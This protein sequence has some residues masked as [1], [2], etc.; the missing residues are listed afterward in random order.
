VTALGLVVA[1]GLAAL[2][3]PLAAHAQSVP[4]M[5]RVGVLVPSTPAAATRQ[6]EA[7]KQWLREHRY[8]DGQNIVV[9]FRYGEGKDERLAELTAELVRTNVDVIV[10]VTDRAVQ[11]AK[12]HTRAIPI[13]MVLASDPV[14]AGFVAS[15]ARPGGNVTGVTVLSPELSGKRLGLLKETVPTVSRVAFV[16]NSDIA[17]AALEYKEIKA[18]AR[19]LK[20]DVQ[21]VDIRRP[22]DIDSALATLSRGQVNALIA[23]ALNPALFSNQDRVAR[24][25]IEQRLPTMYA[26]RSYVDAGSLMSYGPNLADMY[27][28]AATYV[29]K[30]LKG[31]KPGD[32]PVEQPTKFELVIN[33][34]TAKAL[35]LTIPHSLLLRADQ[36]IE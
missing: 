2:G 16:W 13:V 36:V 29:D 30:I 31:A 9:D 15:L 3:A 32:L 11:M 26:T 34:K 22:E 5:P 19:R 28:G 6:I 14:G 7:F 10:A 24:F 18:A 35:G 8:V 21:F 23:A 17:G 25:A 1:F 4:R 27:R 12:Q 20:L 33:L